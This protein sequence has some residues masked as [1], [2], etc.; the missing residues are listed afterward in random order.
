MIVF[1]WKAEK[2]VSLESCLSGT[3][4]SMSDLTLGTRSTAPDAEEARVAAV[5]EGS[6]NFAGKGR[7]GKAGKFRHRIYGHPTRQQSQSE[8]NISLLSGDAKSFNTSFL[9]GA[10]SAPRTHTSAHAQQNKNFTDVKRTVSRSEETIAKGLDTFCSVSFVC[11]HGL[12]HL[13][14]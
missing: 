4:A 7:R 1:R 3:V 10:D 12:I 8:E 11:A 14:L 2:N 13:M 6:P 5:A 9:M